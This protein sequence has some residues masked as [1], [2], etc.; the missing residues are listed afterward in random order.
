MSSEV[1]TH[2]VHRREETDLPSLLAT[3][4]QSKVARTPWPWCTDHDGAKHIVKKWQEPIGN[5]F[6]TALLELLSTAV[7]SDE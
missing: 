1:V 2:S 3:Y 7:P 5:T 4:T 6:V